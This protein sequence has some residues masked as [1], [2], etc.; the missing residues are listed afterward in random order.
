MSAQARSVFTLPKPVLGYHPGTFLERGAAV[1]FTTPH[2]DGARARPAARSGIEFTVPNPSGGRGIYIIPWEGVFAL[3]RPTVHD[4]RLISA[5]AAMRGITPTGIRLAA[6][7]IAAEGLAGRAALA[8]AQAAL[9]AEEKARLLANFDLLLDLVRQVETPSATAQSLEQERGANLEQRARSAVAKIAPVLG[10]SPERIATSLEE[11]ALLFAA[12]GVGRH[13]HSARVPRAVVALGDLRDDMLQWARTHHD[14]TGSDAARI[15]ESAEV[16][17]TC[18]R[19]VLDQVQG[20]RGNMVG[21]LRGWI[22][23]PDVLAD[24]VARPEW[25]MDGWER[26]CLLWRTAPQALGREATLGEMAALVPAL[27]KEAAEWAGMDLPGI[28]EGGGMRRNVSLYE[29]WRT[30]VTVYDI[31]ARNESLRALDP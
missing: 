7:L 28:A 21:L 10:R 3:C 22:Q 20:L 1:P 31:I 13:A 15:A 17:L 25:L 18:V 12:I 29:D 16:T 5:M 30:G 8:S 9:A 23:Q 27:P 4:C 24:L 14:E 26:I 11:L 19:V 2:L 6:R